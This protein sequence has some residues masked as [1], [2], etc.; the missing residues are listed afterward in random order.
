[1][2]TLNLE[3]IQNKKDENFFGEH[4]EGYG[5]KWDAIFEDSAV[6]MVDHLAQSVEKGSLLYRQEING[7]KFALLVYPENSPIQI[8][9][10]IQLKENSNEYMSAYPL[11]EGAN[12][13]L[14]LKSV[15]AW[16]ALAEG[17]MAAETGC[18]RLLNFH[19]PHFA[20]D[21]E[22]FE[23]E[24]PKNVSLAGLAYCIEK[25]KE[26]VHT[27][28]KGGFYE[29]QLKEFLQ[30]NPD[31]SEANFE[32]PKITMGS[33]F[34][35]VVSSE[36]TSVFE[37]VGQIEEISCIQFLNAKMTVLKIN[38]EHSRDDEFLYCNLYVSETTLSNYKPEIGDTIST[39]LWL[40]GY[41]N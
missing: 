20:R 41:F 26:E 7:N 37:A 1:M 2:V 12:N 18:G 40:T 22:C 14:N 21:I 23:S 19:N 29:V 17:E 4:F 32:A 25:L 10:I 39:V 30:E 15:Y 8:M 35:M 16:E 9:S 13:K 6:F 24:K 3:N 5:N 11:M 33:D 34:R 36:T 27:I 28:D 38:F 31:K